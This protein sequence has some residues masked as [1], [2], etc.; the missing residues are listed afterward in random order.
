LPLPN[1]GTA[2]IVVVDRA[3]AVTIVE[4]KLRANPEVRRWVVGQV[5][6]YAAGLWELSVLEF[7]RLW[8]ARAGTSLLS[9]FSVGQSDEADPDAFRRQLENNLRSG[10]FRLVIAVD[11]ITNELKRTVSYINDH[12]VDE[13][14]VLALELKYHAE[15]GIEVLVPTIYGE[16][17]VV[18][19]AVREAGTNAAFIDKIRREV[20][21]EAASFASRFL[22]WADNAGGTVEYSP[23]LTAIA[24]FRVPNYLHLSLYEWPAGKAKLSV[25][26]AYMID[27]APTDWLL[28]VQKELLPL[29]I[30]GAKMRGVDTVAFKKRP[31]IPIEELLAQPNA[32]ESLFTALNNLVASPLGA[33]R[34]GSRPDSEIS[35][36][37]PEH[38]SP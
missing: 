12:T 34:E 30:V 14:Q 27:S 38:S 32:E 22:A 23:S 25:D 24:T 2:D 10:R 13:V 17:A 29:P 37:T 4:C 19:K 20:S 11:E 31:G 16:E 5:F 6:S 28:R 33:D 7:D 1:V 15:T 9:Y 3:A 26:F 35:V 36:D 21:Q 8:Q 18:I